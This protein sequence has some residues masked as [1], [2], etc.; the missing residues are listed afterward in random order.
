MN[1]EIINPDPEF[2]CTFISPYQHIT[3]SYPR[4]KSS[5]FKTGTP[6][7][8][9]SSFFELRIFFIYYTAKARPSLMLLQGCCH[10]AW[11]DFSRSIKFQLLDEIV[12]NMVDYLHLFQDYEKSSRYQSLLSSLQHT[13]GLVCVTPLEK[14]LDP[15]QYW[16]SVLLSTYQQ[17]HAIGLVNVVFLPQTLVS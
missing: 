7:N 13:I 11:V 9:F 4:I 15:T 17:S 6:E 8:L 16:N 2:D 3:I 5:L 10:L 14:I 1:E 12:P